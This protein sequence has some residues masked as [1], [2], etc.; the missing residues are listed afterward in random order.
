M[1]ILRGKVRGHYILLLWSTHP[2]IQMATGNIPATLNTTIIPLKG[3]SVY[4]A[5]L[6]DMMMITTTV[7]LMRSL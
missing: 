3:M 7:R 5:M 1:V 6:P 2:C 4:I